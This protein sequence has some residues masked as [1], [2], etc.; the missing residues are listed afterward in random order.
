MS[1]LVQQLQQVYDDH[2]YQSFCFRQ[3]SPQHLATIAH[4]FGLDAPE[5]ATARVLELGC[6]SGGN[7]IPFAASHPGANAL[8][9]D[10]SPVQI[11][12]GKRRISQL[13]LGNIELRQA[14]LSAVGE[15]LGQFDYIIC[16]G[17]YSW[18]PEHVRSAILRICKD[19]LAPDGIAYVSYNTYPG[20][21]GREIVR[22]AMLLR[23][24]R[25]EGSARE[26][27]AYARGMVDFLKQWADPCNVLGTAV[28]ECAPIIR[29]FADDYLIHD[30][31]EPCN[32]PCYFADFVA[33]AE[34]QGL[35]YLAE[36]EPT[37]MFLSNYGKELQQPLLA[38]CGHSQ[39]LLE[40]YLDFLSNRTFR[41]TLLV[42]AERAA[43]VKYQIDQG[44]LRP[45]SMAARLHCTEEQADTDG[46]QRFQT[47]EGKSLALRSPVV[48]IA[49]RQL[50]A[51]WPRTL[52]VE[53]LMSAVQTELGELPSTA[54]SHIL[55]LFQHLVI[56][57][58]GRYQLT[59]VTGATGANGKPTVDP[60]AIA[61]GELE[62]SGQSPS[63]YNA[64]H[65]TVLL[66]AASAFL[67]PR[68]DGHHSRQQLI[69]AMS[70]EVS[71]GRLRFFKEG[72]LIADAEALRDAMAR[73][74]DRLL[75][76][77][78]A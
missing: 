18:V 53:A 14:D 43:Q 13:G 44:R 50:T 65:E 39:V 26:K 32:A 10:L 63:T 29:D 4:L 75:E 25:C 51:A 64:W 49:A 33:L 58:M 3:S 76:Q 52:N 7:L 61:W 22:D 70:A 77:M 41:Q 57:G 59:P 72:E 27:L 48:K 45:L 60:D 19:N 28:G 62:H 69:D 9:I 40:Q 23:A 24:Q 66:D 30:Y 15:E 37:G 17:V 31:L 36:S 8:G 68:L 71:A 35:S 73:H 54:Q 2:P 1:Q 11:G 46:E 78:V 6:A 5:P 34:G 47:P 12:H 16:H 74:L 67:L 56:Q 21:K 42:H 55:E 20:W 38:E